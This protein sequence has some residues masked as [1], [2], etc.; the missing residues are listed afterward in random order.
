MA[1]VRCARCEREAP[2]LERAPL[3]GEAGL[4]VAKGTCLDCWEAWK[5]EQV[6]QINEYRLSPLDPEHYKR[7]IATMLE[8][9]KLDPQP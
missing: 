7:L 4:L 8:Y 2:G 1:E 3:P 5:V 6:R 9:L